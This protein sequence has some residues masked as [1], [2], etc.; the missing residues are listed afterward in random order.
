MPPAADRH[1]AAD[2]YD[3]QHIGLSNFANVAGGLCE[4]RHQRHDQLRRDRYGR[5]PISTIGIWVRSMR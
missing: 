2:G 3:N 1:V 5:A 4:R